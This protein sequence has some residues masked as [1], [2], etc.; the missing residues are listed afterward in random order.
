MRRPAGMAL[1]GLV[2][3]AS[4]GSR[5]QRAELH[6]PDPIRSVAAGTDGLGRFVVAWVS[7][8]TEL[9]E[10][11]GEQLRAA[12][13]EGGRWQPLGGVVNEK[14]QYNAAQ[15][16]VHAGPD[17]SV[18]LEWEEGSGHAHIDSFLMSNWTGRAWTRPTPYAL[19]RNLS[20]AGR[21][22]A[23][24]LD[25]QNRPLVGWTDIGTGTR[26]MYPSVVSL[27][28][29]QGR[30]WLTTPY[31]NLNLR[32]PAFMPSV[33]HAGGKVSVAYVEGPT[34]R[35]NIWVRQWT[36]E[37]WRTL[38]RRVN[39]RPD[40]YVFRPLLRADGLGRLTVAWLEDLR[41]A[42]TLYVSRWNGRVWERLGSGPV[43]RP[44]EHAATASLAFDGQQ[45]PV[46]AWT[47]G[48]DG[49]RTVRAV[50]WDG[51]RWLPLGGGVLN[52]TSSADVDHATVAGSRYGILVAWRELRGGVWQ[53]RT[54][55]Q[56]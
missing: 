42:D 20:D 6:S 39:V 52:A 4:A 41:G 40:T 45:R 48:P 27:K 34:T 23:L 56:P 49:R 25:P 55:S 54:W 44:G 3:V 2:A 10:G 51:S 33:A 19:R 31:L 35:S 5:D 38:G 11:G 17:G 29:W 12:R 32:Q 47:Q 26:S 14:P 13:L 15:P 7:C 43:S 28:L 9:A 8:R 18:W 30:G 36:P 24:A 46:V 50:R 37:G 16:N 22:R 1:L 53:L 21:S